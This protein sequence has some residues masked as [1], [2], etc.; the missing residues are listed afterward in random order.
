MEEDK[1]VART[2]ADEDDG[3]THINESLNKPK[4]LFL[5]SPSVF[6]FS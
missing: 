3:K 6:P 5:G 2:T 1:N 4:R